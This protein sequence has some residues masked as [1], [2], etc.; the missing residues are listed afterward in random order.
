MR[1]PQNMPSRTAAPGPASSSSAHANGAQ[2]NS[3]G[4]LAPAAC[5]AETCVNI[6][7]RGRVCHCILELPVCP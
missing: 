5:C 2:R 6:P 7:F 3:G 4:G 1:I